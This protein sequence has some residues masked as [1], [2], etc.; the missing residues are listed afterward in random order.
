MIREL[1][2][3]IKKRVHE[4]L[5]M[6]KDQIDNEI[7]AQVREVENNYGNIVQTEELSD[8]LDVMKA[9]PSIVEAASQAGIPLQQWVVET[10]RA[11]AD[12]SYA[13]IMIPRDAYGNL[14]RLAYARGVTLETL[15]TR[16]EMSEWLKSG[17]DNGR[18]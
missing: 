16:P 1:A 14:T 10:L 12:P 5:D 4:N 3:D 17:L 15:T 11:V 7:E 6:T 8:A 13:S 9:I 2:E 18:I